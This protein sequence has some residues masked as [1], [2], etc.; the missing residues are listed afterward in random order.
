[1]LLSIDLLHLRYGFVYKEFVILSVLLCSV[2]IFA[3]IISFDSSI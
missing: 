2:L 3:I 1:M